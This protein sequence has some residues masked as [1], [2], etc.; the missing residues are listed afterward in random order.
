MKYRYIRI[1]R[2][3]LVVTTLNSTTDLCRLLADPTRLRLVAVL[4]VDAFTV[5]EIVRITSTPQPRISTHLGLLR[6][7]GLVSVRRSGSLGFY[8]REGAAWE[9]EAGELLR[10]IVG[11]ARD[12]ILSNDRAAARAVIAA[13]DEE[14]SWVDRVAGDMARHYSPGRTWE[15]LARGLAGLSPLGEVIDIGAGDGAVAELLAPHAVSVTALD[16]S[17]TVVARARA[18]LA[19][20]QELRFIEGDMHALPFPDASFDVAL[21]MGCLVWSPQPEGALAEAARVLRPGGRLTVVTLAAHPHTAIAARYGHRHPGHSPTALAA[22][23]QDLGLTVHTCALT[24]RERRA[25]HFEVVSAH[26]SRPSG[27]SP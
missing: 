7:A 11:G 18:R 20:L 8:R 26:A 6:E 17:P 25:P 4:G 16:L 9:G 14:G 10:A 5:A 15:S 23:L 1:S 19:H 12:P 21:M 27:D 2:Y 22:L 13:R 3:I 24:S